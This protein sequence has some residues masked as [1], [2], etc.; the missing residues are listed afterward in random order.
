MGKEHIDEIV[1]Q[2]FTIFDKD[3][4]GHLDFVEFLC[5]TDMTSHG[6][7]EE[8]LRW[9]FK[10]YDKDGSGTLEKEELVFFMAL[11]FQSKV[12]YKHIPMGPGFSS[13]LQGFELT[14]EEAV[15][16]AERLFDQIDIN[17]EGYINE[18]EFVAVCLEDKEMVERLQNS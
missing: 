11:V 1:S 15:R 8:K 13:A 5:A 3:G 9:N 17:G 4:N 6:T 2:I 10:A 14:Q 16:K 18:E 12:Y 7:L